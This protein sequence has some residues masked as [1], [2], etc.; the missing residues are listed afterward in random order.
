MSIKIF[1]HIILTLICLLVVSAAWAQRQKV[2][3]VLSGGGAKGVAHISVLKVIEEAGIP[4]DYIAGTSM[5]AI[6][7]GLYAVG[8]DTHTLDSLVR[9]QNWT[10]L[11]SD[12]VSRRYLSFSAKE[13]S[14]RYL[15]TLPLT[16]QKKFQLP[17]GLVGGNNVYNL[18]TE[19]TIDYHDSISFES[20]PVPFAC[21]A[22]DMVTGRAVTLDE[23]YLARA[24]RASMSI[25]GA[26]EP[27]H[28]DGMVLIDGG[29]SNNFPADVVKAMGADIIIGVDVTAGARAEDQ[30]NTL[31]DMF[32]QITYFTGVEAYKKN[33]PLVD[34]YIKPDITGYGAGSFSAEAI[35]TLLV[36]GEKAAYERFGELMALRPRIG[37]EPGYMPQEREPV[38][39][40]QPLPLANI[41][42]E[43]LHYQKEKT[44][45]R[46]AGLKDSTF[47][48]PSDIQVAVEKLQ[49]TENLSEVNYR[50]EGNA[51]Y[52]LVFMVKESTRNSISLG[53]RVDTEEMAAILL[54][55]NLA[56]NQMSN[57]HFDVTARLSEN[58]YIKGS[59]IL[60]N[61]AERKMTLSYMYKY[62]SLG[63]YNRGK[64]LS[65][66]DF[67]QHTVELNF[68]NIR[69]RNFKVGVGAI[70]EYLDLKA[71]LS[72]RE[73]EVNARSEGMFM[74]RASAQ[75]ETLDRRYN[76]NRGI[77]FTSDYTFYT[78][79]F[80]NYHGDTPFSAL[81]ADFYAAL[82]MNRRVT[83]IPGVF[84]RVI[85]GRNAA[86]PALNVL[87]GTVPGRYFRQQMPFVGV[88]RFEV[89]DNAVLGARLD[90]RGR[91]GKKYFVSMK[92]NYMKEQ[93]SFSD[94][95]KGKD[96]WGVGVAGSVNTLLGPI[97]LLVDYSNRTKK[98]GI[99]ANLGY[100][101]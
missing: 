61:E 92:A 53:L 75:V 84:S 65:N 50:L 86:F 33:L 73:V 38:E 83:F 15:I 30:L 60:G 90:V 29:I 40:D 63:Y 10:E 12:R 8:Y 48:R 9:T 47:V 44:L 80:V 97:D 24:I 41:R 74:Y 27:V 100:Y 77:S 101:F 68:A 37:L 87:G 71:A 51:P 58:P 70:Y 7:G 21:V 57:S 3:V 64:K 78:S 6:I 45:S 72:T 36:R 35:D 43:G 52:D 55:V 2:G 96:I 89:F 39:L 76:P 26:F 79:N 13:V 23:G 17:S 88:H 34:V 99:Y 19:L 82:S 93:H 20:L 16:S 22:Y 98:V 94:I 62:N 59:Y 81:H 31:S 18:L 66:L 14:E 28:M 56:A 46:I 67:N 25:P 49:G 4:I 32:N 69:L 1:R 54:N 85:M 95:L 91:I 11:L 5:G 42:F